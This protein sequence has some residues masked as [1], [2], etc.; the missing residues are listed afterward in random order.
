MRRISIIP[1]PL[2]IEQKLS[3]VIDVYYVRRQVVIVIY[4]T[5]LLFTRYFNYESAIHTIT[6][7]VTYKVY[8][9]FV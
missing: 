8:H 4:T 1:G 9:T 6:L 2:V 7:Y 3:P 5:G